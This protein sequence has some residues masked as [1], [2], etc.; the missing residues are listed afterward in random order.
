[1]DVYLIRHGETN[2][3]KE[4]RL[5]GRTDIPLNEEGLKQAQICAKA[6][7]K[8]KFTRV[9]TSPLTRARQTAEAIA[10]EL[11]LPIEVMEQ[12]IER[13]FGVAEGKTD[14]VIEELYPNNEIPEL[15]P[16]NELIGRIKEGLDNIIQTSQKDSHI[17]IVAHGAV[18][19]RFVAH[20]AQQELGQATNTSLTHL[21]YDGN[22]W[23]V[24]EVNNRAYLNATLQ[25]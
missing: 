11:A 5:Q 10:N 4:K 23:T 19:N 7:P 15:E 22:K 12:F 9:I 13:S 17:I 25:L 8:N 24:I 14:D 21:T 1:M 2:W 3:N 18:I 16:L 6:L 20:I